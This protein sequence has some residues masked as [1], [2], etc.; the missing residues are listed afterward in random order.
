LKTDEAWQ[1]WWKSV[2]ATFEF[3]P[4]AQKSP[5][6]A[7]VSS[8]PSYY[9]IPMYG[10]KI[11]FVIDASGSMRGLRI[12]AAKRELIK[13]IYDLPDGT[14]FNVLAFSESV[15]PWQRQLTVASKD[16]K[17][18]AMRFVE[19]LGLSSQT[20]SY[21]ALEAALTFDAEAIFFLTDGQ[22]NGG[23]ISQPAK[24]VNV[25][26]RMNRVRRVTINSIGIGVGP[27]GSEFDLFMKALAGENFGGY[28][29]VDE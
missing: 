10:S 11:V 18:A 15:L 23:K 12:E 29:R 13:A 25:I 7:F 1:A 28:R 3:P 22:P 14:E 17:P 4:A 24:I 20:H 26:S 6:A 16:T 8:A 21:D 27:S 5:V 9:G 19:L 2:V